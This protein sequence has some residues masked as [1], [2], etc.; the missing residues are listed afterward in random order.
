MS[1]SYTLTEQKLVKLLGETNILI[2]SIDRTKIK[3]IYPTYILQKRPLFETLYEDFYQEVRAAEAEEK[4]DEKDGEKDDIKDGIENKSTKD[5]QMEQNENTENNLKSRESV[6][7]S[8]PDSSGHPKI[9]H[10]FTGD[11]PILQKLSKKSPTSKVDF[12]RLFSITRCYQRDEVPTAKEWTKVL[13]DDDGDEGDSIRT[14]MRKLRRKFG[15][16]LGIG[17]GGNTK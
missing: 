9:L 4:G 1:P 2:Q 3:T 5:E 11:E 15:K 13:F 10:I 12:Q 8:K 7:N 14:I 6:E 17:G 16:L